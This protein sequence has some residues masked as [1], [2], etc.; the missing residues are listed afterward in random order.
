M[1]TK[2]RTKKKSTARTAAKSVVRKTSSHRATTQTEQT[3]V[4]NNLKSVNALKSPSQRKLPKVHADIY[5]LQADQLRWTC[6][7][8]IF[9]FKSTAE[10][11]P[12]NGI[13]GQ[14]RAIEAIRL[15]AE[16]ASRGFNIFVMSLLGTGR[17][18]TIQSVLQ[19][20]VKAHQTFVDYAYVHNFKNP[21]M[22]RLLK[23]EAGGGRVFAKTMEDNIALL[24][25]QIPQLFDDHGFRRSRNELVKRFRQD[26]GLLL[27]NFDEHLRKHGFTL[28]QIQGE[29][30]TVAQEIFVLVHD[31]PVMIDELDALVEKG[32]ISERRAQDRRDH[33][34]QYRDELADLARKQMQ[35]AQSFRSALL[36]HDRKHAAY[37][38]K[39][40]FQ[41]QREQYEDPKI[42]EYLSECEHDL[43]ENIEIFSPAHSDEGQDSVLSTGQNISD[44]LLQYSV[45]VIVD[46]SETKSPPIIIESYPTYVN[47]FGTIEKKIDKNG[48]VKTDFTQIKPG[49]LLRADGGYLI[50][51]ASDL[52]S[53][54]TVW[55]N[56][57]RV[58]LYGRMEIQAQDSSAVMNT[59][60]KP[61]LIESN[62]KVIMLGNYETYTA[63]YEMDEDF[64]KMFKIPAEFDYETD[65]ADKMLHNYARFIAKICAEEKLPHANPQGVA[66]I[67]EWAVAQTE[68]KNKITI[69]FSEVAD[70]IREAAYF[71]KQEKKR[72]LG[73]SSV[74][75]AVKMR[76]HRTELQDHKIQS[77]ILQGTVLIDTSG[78]RVGQI[79]GLTVYSTGLISFGKPARISVSTSAGSA[80]IVNIERESE[81]SGNI[82]TKGV[83]IISGLLRELFAQ[84]RPLALTATV[85]F[86]Q[87][88]GG[89]DGDSASAAEIY[90]LLSSLAQQPISQSIACTGSINQKGD[91]QPVGGVNEKIKGFF[92]ICAKRGLSGN[93][94]VIIPYQNVADLM[95][96]E[97][98]I[99]AVRASKFHIY[100]IS[101][102]EEAIP[103]L[104]GVEAGSLRSDYSYA[105][106][107]LFHAVDKRLEELYQVALRWELR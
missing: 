85:A 88:Y 84:R 96:D 44:K 26:E 57:K 79:N 77:Q 80:G 47:L 43:L 63:L 64:K 6:D 46:N 16:I 60:L 62:V 91:I 14:H 97:T 20:V 8:K 74:E 33:F 27:Q 87:N 95:L 86:E 51:N 39:A 4:R 12:L 82:H 18:T 104:M 75:K 45:N 23:F 102:F 83:Y 30:G 9:K 1:S 107:T 73:R 11:E 100:P 22:P 70:L 66:S 48:Y 101:R 52:L 69:N 55:H 10:L 25:R 92:E 42:H 50:V 54:A 78:S 7:H 40:V 28:G 3:N 53:D 21:D 90:A 2:N 34:M 59:A 93:Q 36:E 49:A 81:F 105:E 72:V 89:V 19:R 13:V 29:D 76:H 71:A 38:V 61:E 103:I 58:L 37:S 15:G 106:G 99:E 68:D 94:G 17:L 65:R 35:V 41:S 31:K 24:R 56:L 98:V 32:E 67:V 5:E